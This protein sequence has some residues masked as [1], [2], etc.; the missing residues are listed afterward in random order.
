VVLSGAFWM[1]IE[2]ATL[3][4]VLIFLIFLTNVHEGNT[5]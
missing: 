4:F 1:V 5:M 2:A 3:V